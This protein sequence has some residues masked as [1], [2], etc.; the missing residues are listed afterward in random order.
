MKIALK[1]T[2]LV[3]ALLLTASCMGGNKNE[4]SSGAATS[5][6]PSSSQQ[7]TPAAVRVMALKGPTAMGMVELMR[8]SDAGELA[9]DDYSFSI[10]SAV[11]E[12]PPALVQGKA[13]I[14]AVPANLASVLYN[15]TDGAVQVLAVNTLGVLYL[16]GD[17]QSSV[18]SVA[19]LRGRT[20]YASG[21]GATPEYALQYLL[22]QNGLDAETDLQIEWKSEHAECV[23]ALLADP[24]AIALLPQPFVTT[25]LMKNEGLGILLDLNDAWEATQ[26]DAEIPGALLTGVLVARR[27]FVRQNPQ[28]VADFM[29]RYADSVAFVQQ[30]TAQAAELVGQYDIVPEPVALQA[31]PYCNIVCITG[32]EM[33]EKLSGYLAVLLEQNPKAVGGALP[34]DDFYYM[35]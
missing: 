35:A 2:A 13:D 19:A 34:G 27:E 31:L 20:L 14:A 3:L 4:N 26:K 1:T 16:V 15:N 5:S 24:T 33:R 23:A 10:V 6:T 32:E 9:P 11:D 21:K 30:N 28:A 7:A 22:A 29:R 8:Q 25:A 12:V 17:A 18:D